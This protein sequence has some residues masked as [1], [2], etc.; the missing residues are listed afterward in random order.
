MALIKCPEC[1]KEVSDSA[2]TCPHCGYVLKKTPSTTHYYESRSSRLYEQEYTRKYKGCVAAGIICL[3]FGPLFL[4]FLPHISQY[5][6]ELKGTIIGSSI[7]FI[8]GG[9]IILIIG[10]V[11]LRE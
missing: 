2:P 4:L 1:G 9:I 6:Y 10:I 7:G 11:R 5:D 3:I 8:I